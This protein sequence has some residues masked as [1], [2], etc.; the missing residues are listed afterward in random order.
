MYNQQH[1]Q[2]IKHFRKV[3]NKM[4]I[5]IYQINRNRDLHNVK[6]KNYEGRQ[7]YQGMADIDSSIYDE[8][9]MGDVL[10]GPFLSPEI[11]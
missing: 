7:K 4:K 5:K 9:F 6:F 11:W 2:I 1:R 10:C 3:E 8:V